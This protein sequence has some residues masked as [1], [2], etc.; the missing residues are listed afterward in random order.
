M[1]YANAEHPMHI[2]LSEERRT[3][4]LRLVREFHE[5]KF[6]EELSPFRAETLLDF[7]LKELGPPVY[8]QAIAHAK[9]FM[10]EKLED[11]DAEFYEPES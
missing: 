10:V 6:D 3:A 11:L 9:A 1:P 4:L 2:V 7:F 8:N 5:E